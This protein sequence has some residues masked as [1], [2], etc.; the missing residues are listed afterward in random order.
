MRICLVARNRFHSDRKALATHR[1]LSQA[2]HEIA[3]VAVDSHPARPPVTSTVARRTGPSNRIGSLLD[4]VLPETAHDLL[5]RR[6]LAR[7]GA[8]TGADLFIPLHEDVVEVAVEAAR[9][10]GGMVQRTPDMTV[11]ADVD[12]IWLAPSQPQLAAPSHGHGSDF[13]SRRD[14]LRD[15]PQSG[16]YQGE[17]VVICYRKTEANPGRYVEAAL[18]RSGLDVRVETDAIDLDTVD[19]SA[20]FVLFVE[21]PYPAID[22]RGSTPVPVLFWAHHGEH[23]LFANVR[24]TRRYAADAV[25]LAHSWHL[26]HWFPT[27]VH[28][29]PFAVP[30]ELFT[31]VRP[32]GDR[33]FDVAMVGSKLRGDAWQYQRRHQLVAE[34]EDRLGPSRAHFVEGVSPEEMAR[35]YGQA[36]IVLNEGGTRHYPITMRVFEAIGSGAALLTDPVPGLDILFDPESEYAE[37]TSDV[38][39]DV[40][41]LVDGLDATQTMADR[42]RGRAMGAHTYDHRVDQLVEIA[43]DLPKREPGPEPEMGPLARLIDRDVEVQRVIQQ[44]LDSLADQLPDREIWPLSERAGRMRAGNMDAAVITS[45]DAALMTDLLDSARRYIYVGDGVTGLDGY[46]AENHPGAVTSGEGSPRRVILKTESY[47][48]DPAGSST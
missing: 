30:P 5:L 8:A 38:V 15:L 47:R 19:P 6:R 27:P 45:G 42:A 32:L 10:C 24:L 20:L 2:G 44:G 14:D 40:D 29:F 11:P 23:H 34:L 28:R 13:T 16:R 39:A 37:L 4:R 9:A 46:L 36:R 31:S 1:V 43:A 18:I 22:V 17:Q 26:A 48:V 7:A 33:A 21:S 35:I 12:L 41:R 3:V 25:L